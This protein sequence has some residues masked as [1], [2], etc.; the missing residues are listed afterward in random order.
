VRILARHLP[1]L[2]AIVMALAVGVALGAGPLAAAGKEALSSEQAGPSRQ[3]PAPDGFGDEY[4]AATARRLLGKKLAGHSVAVLVAPGADDE[5]VSGVRSMIAT[6]GARATVWNL[7]EGL[8]SGGQTALVDT[9]GQQMI[10]QSKLS[11]LDP[12]LTA[13]PRLGRL[14][15]RAVA[16][17]YGGDVAPDPVTANLRASLSGADLVR[18]QPRQTRASA[19]VVVLGTDANDDVLAGLLGGL[20]QGS[21]TTVVVA[22]GRSGALAVASD[23]EGVATVDGVDR[24][25]AQVATVL[26][27]IQHSQDGDFGASGSDGPAPLG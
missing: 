17:L 5:A 26:A 13:Y 19:V 8:L 12:K 6:A 11:G 15:A 18:G 24:V 22:P 21:A 20:A 27:L 14:I 16:T 1:A 3:A 10:K 2:V 23:V 9:L 7:E 4:A 25:P